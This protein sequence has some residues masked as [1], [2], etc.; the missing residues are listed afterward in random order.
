MTSVHTPHAHA[1]CKLLICWL[2]FEHSCALLPKHVCSTYPHIHRKYPYT[3]WEPNL[4]CIRSASVA[5]T[6]RVALLV[7][8]HNLV[9]TSASIMADPLARPSG[10]GEKS[11]MWDIEARS[12]TLKLWGCSQDLGCTQGVETFSN[13][14]APVFSKWIWV[15]NVSVLLVLQGAPKRTTTGHLAWAKPCSVRGSEVEPI[16]MTMRHN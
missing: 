9:C 5:T 7:F 11:R 13:Q 15:R 16:V 1:A 4:G 2:Y 10:W 8:A 12:R 3:W 14:S 6:W